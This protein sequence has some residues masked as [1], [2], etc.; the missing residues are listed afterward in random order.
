[1]RKGLLVATLAVCLV[2]LFSGSPLLAADNWLGTWKLNTEKSKFSPGP[3]PKS[4]TAKFEASGDSITLTTDGVSAKGQTTHSSYTSK[5]DGKEVPW[6]GS[7]DAD[8]AAPKRIDAS[9]YENVSKKGGKVT[10]TSKIVASKDGKTLTVT[11]MGKSAAGETVNNTL[12]FD[13]Q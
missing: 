12:V 13:K 6:T 7:P 3:A 5:F 2:V 8:T 4:M 1:M 10:I 9:S 11:Q